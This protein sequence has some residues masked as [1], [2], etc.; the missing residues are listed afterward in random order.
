MSVGLQI[1]HLGL[2]LTYIDG[3]GGGQG[4]GVLRKTETA[5]QEGLWFLL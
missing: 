2:R 4:E 3:G 5:M 1:A